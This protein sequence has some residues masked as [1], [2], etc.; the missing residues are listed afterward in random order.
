MDLVHSLKRNRQTNGVKGT[1]M[2]QQYGQGG[3]SGGQYHAYAQGG[4][5]YGGQSGG[6]GQQGGQ[7]GFGQSGYGQGGFG[8]GAVQSGGNY[9]QGYG[10]S[11]G[12]FG[13]QPRGWESGQGY[14]QGSDLA[15]NPYTMDKDYDLI[16]VLYHALQ[17]AETCAK[18]RQ[19]AQRQGS[20]EIAAF[21]EQVQQQNVQI[22]L[23]AKELLLRQRQV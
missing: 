11:Q 17:A 8:Q 5:Q 16:S 12:G 19:D 10:S 20:P 13:A 7:G 21:M 3:G 4:S 1:R 22:S 23:R 14:R 6:Y 2:N 18:Y 15:F 9:G